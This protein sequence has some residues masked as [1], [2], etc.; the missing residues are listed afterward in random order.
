ML[1]CLNPAERTY[2]KGEFIFESEE[3]VTTLGAVLE[4]SVHIVT[5]DYSGNRRIVARAERGEMFASAPVCAG[6]TAMP[7]GAVA[8]ENS[9][10][11]RIEY[12]RVLHACANACERH[13]RMIENMVLALARENVELTAKLRHITRRT[14]RE[15]L[16][17]YLTEQAKTRGAALFDI[18]FNR[19]ELADYLAVERSKMSYELSRLKA[20][21]VIDYR[22][23]HF[24][25]IGGR[26][27]R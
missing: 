3:N 1:E 11:L 19:Q 10:V 9:R 6:V 26:A 16:L 27:A 17:S 14:T 24:E 18:P 21:G 13:T 22:K 12:S 7:Y 23:N 4:G 2:A 15:K 8:A 20:E 5:D 25:M